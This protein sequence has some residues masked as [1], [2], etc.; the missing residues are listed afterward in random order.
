MKTLI[1]LTLIITSGFAQ[2]NQQ[3]FEDMLGTWKCCTMVKNGSDTIYDMRDLK[4]QIS[5]AILGKGYI[6]SKDGKESFDYDVDDDTSIVIEATMTTGTNALD[7]LKRQYFKIEHYE[8]TFTLTLSIFDAQW[9][10]LKIRN[11]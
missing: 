3:L 9:H 5:F 6:I 8:D 2:W 1:F 7:T 11:Y 4:M 10:F